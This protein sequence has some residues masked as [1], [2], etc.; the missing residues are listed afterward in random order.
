MFI[1]TLFTLAR[2]RT[3][4]KCLSAVRQIT[5]I[6]SRYKMEYYSTVKKNEV[7]TF[8]GKW[9]DVEKSVLSEVTDPER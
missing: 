7:T 4:P 5:K 9:I 8:S 3:Q 6:W 2:K 1:T